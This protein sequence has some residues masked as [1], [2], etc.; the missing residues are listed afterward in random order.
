MIAQW[1]GQFCSLKQ[2]AQR[3]FAVA[4]RKISQSKVLIISGVV[5]S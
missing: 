5:D 1:Q 4:A 3:T 2:N